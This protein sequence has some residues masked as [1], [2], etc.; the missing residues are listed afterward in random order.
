MLIVIFVKCKVKKKPYN[1]IISYLLP[2]NDCWAISMARDLAYALSD[3]G[4]F[5]PMLKAGR[6]GNPRSQFHRYSISRF[7]G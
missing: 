3:S 4:E 1:I 7:N 2:L 6:Y 5:G